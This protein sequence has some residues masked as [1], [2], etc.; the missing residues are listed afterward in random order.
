MWSYQYFWEGAKEWSS[1]RINQLQI[2]KNIAF[3]IIDFIAQ[4]EDELVKIW[5]KPKFVRNSNYVITLDRISND[6]LVRKLL[7]HG[8]MEKQIDEWR[9]LGIVIGDFDIRTITDDEKYIHLPF[10]TKYFKDM[11][12]EI[13]ALFDNLDDQLDGRLIKSENYQALNT[14]LP[15]FKEKV[16]TIYIDP[17]FNTGDDFAYVDRFQDS[18]WLSLMQNRLDKAKLFI[19]KTGGLVLHLDWNANYLGRNLIE[20]TFGKE[21]F[22]NEVIW[23][24][25][26]VSGYKTQ[27]DAFVRNHDTIYIFAKTNRKEYF[28]RKTSSKI[29][30]HSFKT[31]IIED[32]LRNIKEKWGIENINIKNVKLTIKDEKNIVYKIGLE[33]KEGE[34]NIEDTWNS[35]EYED[36][37]SNK[38]KRNAKEYTP[39]GSEIT[40]KPE[41]LLQRIIGLTTEKGQCVLDY[42]SGSGTTVAVAHKLK[43]KWIGI[44]LA[45]YFETDI[46]FRMKQVLAGVGKNEPCGISKEIEW[47]GGGFF[48]YYKLEQYEESLSNCKYEDGDLFNI[49]S[50]SP[51]QQYVFLKDEKMLRSLDI[52]LKNNQIN[53]DLSSLYP[54]IDIPETLSNLTGKWIKRIGQHLVEFTDST[55]ININELDYKLIKPLIWWE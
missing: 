29:P 48:K 8:G 35:S 4:F 21:N 51:Y 11:E 37:H 10:D 30:Y 46:L 23:R 19:T 13:L 49:P 50:T 55:T 7:K 3:K 44:E 20:E 54:D 24:I 39:N 15:K 14:I 41:Q 31:S 40:Q 36:L 16:Q 9:A 43:R 18:T 45:T 17:P 32:E 47:K 5:N 42:F 27:V 52:D 28:F 6:S 53:I 26:W 34:Y 1:Q 12:S 2:L 33:T 22:I 25:G 38:I